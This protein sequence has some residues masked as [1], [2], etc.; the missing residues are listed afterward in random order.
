[1]TKEV[2]ANLHNQGEALIRIDELARGY[3]ALHASLALAEESGLDRIANFDRIYLAYLDA[4]DG[5]PGADEM[6][7]S[8]TQLAR[9]QNWT[10]DHLTGRYLYAKVLASRDG[11]AEARQELLD[12][13]ALALEAGNRPLARDC[14]FELEL[15]EPTLADR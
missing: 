12:V 11:L 9:A 8:R 13:R 6:L 5:L 2:A 15:T 1:L 14:A 3:A 4:L 10:F 7:Q